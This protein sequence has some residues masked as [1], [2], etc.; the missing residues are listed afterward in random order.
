MKDLWD[1]TDL[2][3]DDKVKLYT[4]EMNNFQTYYNRLAD[5]PP[6][7]VE[8]AEKANPI[9]VKLA[10]PKTGNHKNDNNNKYKQ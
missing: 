2:H 8:M 5:T 4:K 3:P 9:K 6:V 1:L 10:H 7:K